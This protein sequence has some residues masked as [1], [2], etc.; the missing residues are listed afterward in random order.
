MVLQARLAGWR[1]VRTA[2]A[3][4]AVSSLAKTQVLGSSNLMVRKTYSRGFIDSSI[5]V[6]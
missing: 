6:G 4:V 3:V 5:A 1:V 2:L